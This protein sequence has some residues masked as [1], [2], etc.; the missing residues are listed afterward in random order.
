MASTF[1]GGSNNDERPEAIAVDPDGNVVIFSSVESGDFP[2]TAGV[3]QDSHPS[4]NFFEYVAVTVMSPDLTTVLRST[5][6]GG[7]DSSDILKDGAVDQN[8]FIYVT[9]YSDSSDRSSRSITG[10]S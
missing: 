6:L 2:T 7:S 10:G 1:L 9:G 3:I 4:G 5:Y 8:G